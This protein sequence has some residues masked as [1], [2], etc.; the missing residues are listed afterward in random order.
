MGAG[1]QVEQRY[2]LLFELHWRRVRAY[3]L[4]RA[5]NPM[6]ADDVVA[7]VFLTAW[8]RIADI[9][10]DNELAWLLAVARRVLANTYRGEARRERLLERIH[11]ATRTIRPDEMSADGADDDAVDL[12][13]RAL[14][15]LPQSDAEI[16]Q[17]ATWE[18][19]AHA[20]IALVLDCSVN[21]VAIRLHRARQRLAAELGKESSN[22][23]HSEP[24]AIPRP[25]S[26]CE[27]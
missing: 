27:S 6:T 12:V 16:L 23:G 11:Q 7:D 9:P 22:A 2:R 4:R 20:Q 15:R 19:L 26:E 5:A 18:Q 17:L 10:A 1:S 8:R 13:R 3:A 24:N 14:G 21:A 25:V